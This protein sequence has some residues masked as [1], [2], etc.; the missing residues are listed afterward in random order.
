MQSNVCHCSAGTLTG[1]QLKNELMQTAKQAIAETANTSGYY[2]MKHKFE[3][4]HVKLPWTSLLLLKILAVIHPHF[5]NQNFRFFISPCPRYGSLNLNEISQPV[6]V[7]L[8]HLGFFKSLFFP[9]QSICKQIFVNITSASL[10]VAVFPHSCI[11][12]QKCSLLL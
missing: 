5:Q 12:N 1:Y 11:Y 6:Q 4:I 7:K 2:Q 10:S 8:Q 9:V 3:S